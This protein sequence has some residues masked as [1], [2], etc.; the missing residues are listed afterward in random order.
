MTAKRPTA[1]KTI[2]GYIAAFAPEV[3]KILEKI[4]R[5]IRKVA[6]DAQE[7]IS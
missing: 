5:T 1:A 2:D 6:P 4:R 3:R 7:T